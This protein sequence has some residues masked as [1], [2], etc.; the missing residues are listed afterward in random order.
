SADLC[1]HLACW[2]LMLQQHNFD[3]VYQPGSKNDGPDALNDPFFQ[4]LCS[5]SLPVGFT[6]KSGILFFGPWPVLPA[7]MR[8]EIFELL[9][10]NPTSGHLGIGR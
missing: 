1:G 4:E 6:N 10:A 2:A 9:H 7:S 8:D 5:S 3:I